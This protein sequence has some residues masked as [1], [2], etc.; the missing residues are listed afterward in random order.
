MKMG[1]L[2]TDQLDE[3]ILKQ[4]GSYADMFE[5]LFRQVYP[6][7][8]FSTYSV[9]NAHYP[10]C[11]D[12]CDA[13]LI[14]GSKFSAYENLAWIKKLNDYI[15]LLHKARKTMLGICFG[16]QLIAQALGGSTRKAEQG[17]GIGYMPVKVHVQQR[18]MD[19]VM[20]N[21]GLLVSHQDQV[22]HLPRD[23]MLLAG[24]PFCPNACYQIGEHILTFQGHPE[25]SKNYSQQS[26][27]KRRSI[28]GDE[29][30]DEGIASLSHDVD[31]LLVTQWMVNFIHHSRLASA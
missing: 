30:V 2:E 20:Q 4:Y 29:R 11:Y 19:P 26:M 23:A 1:I 21:M 15:Q 5:Q 28:I 17:W 7:M 13:Y 14:T 12:E 22:E 8:T 16:H 31:G 6:S 18:W 24:S 27:E 3:H 25:F 10:A 9:I